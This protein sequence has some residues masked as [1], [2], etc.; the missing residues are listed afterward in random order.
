MNGKS[1]ITNEELN[2]AVSIIN[3]IMGYYRQRIV[4]Q[5]ELGRSL[6]IA[7]MANGHILLESVPG[8]AKTTAAKIITNAVSGDFSRIQCTPDLLPSDIIG[9]QI[10]NYSTSSFETKLI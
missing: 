4:G 2:R 10:F 6:L 1:D 9:G 3:S 7:L 5:E 8:L